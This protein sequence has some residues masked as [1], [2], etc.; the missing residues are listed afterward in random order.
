MKRKFFIGATASLLIA[1]GVILG[2][3]HIDAPGVT[4]TGPTS[5]ETDITDVYVFQSPADNS[6]MVFVLNWQGL[7]SPAKT[8]T[9]TIPN[10]EL[11]EF[12]IDNS[13]DNVED[14]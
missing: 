3:D 11:F 5:L 2:A 10:N 9:A 6:K 13:G 8:A 7:M 14:L 1:G 12:N 4:G